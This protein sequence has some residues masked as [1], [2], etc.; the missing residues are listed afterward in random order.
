MSADV[1]HRLIARQRARN[2]VF[3]AVAAAAAVLDAGIVVILVAAATRMVAGVVAAAIAAAV[4]AAVSLGQAAGS[5]RR[6]S[7]EPPDAPASA[8]L[9]PIAA[10]LAAR[11]GIEEPELWIAGDD[12]VNA[13]S[14]ASGGQ[15]TLFYTRGFLAE[16]D[17]SDGPLIEAVT[18]HLLARTAAGDDTATIMSVGLLNWALFLFHR[19]M[20]GFARV[21]RVFGVGYLTSDA[22]QR[23]KP[24]GLG[25]GDDVVTR[26]AVWGISVFIGLCLIAASVGVV[27]VG[28]ILVVVAGGVRLGLTRQRIRIADTIAAELVDDPQALL[29]AFGR[30]SDI[31]QR[32][33]R[34]L[35]L[36]HSGEARRDLCFHRPSHH[37]PGLPVR[38]A[39]AA[40]SSQAAQPGV[41]APIASVLAVACL[42]G[43]VAFATVRVPYGQ[44]FGGAG[45]QVPQANAAPLATVSGQAAGTS[46]PSPSSAS[47]PSPSSSSPSPTSSVSPTSSPSASATSSLPTTPSPSAEVVTP[48]PPPPTSP[49]A[50]TACQPDGTGCTKGGTYP[51]PNA[52]INSD[53]GG[54]EVTWSST[55]VQPYSSGVPL[56]WTAGVTYRNIDSVTLTLGC[57]GSWANASVIQEYMSGGAGDDGM[58][59]AG[60]TTCSQNP[61]W[62]ATVAP[63]H[64]VVVYATFH[65]VPWPGSA[66]AITWGD[67]GTSASIYPFT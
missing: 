43:A 31:G 45:P 58:V 62:T 35:E 8:R 2:R 19:V 1:V 4:M 30:F 60:S 13:F 5:T 38:A 14:A 6:V 41:L 51:D 25:Y 29:A 50:A 39:S 32:G 44:P 23:L 33:D 27:L 22:H 7:G 11:L 37:Y 40:N 57:G 42:I 53:Y 20:R 15:V 49:P 64:T 28:G 48:P 52:V 3:I 59:P 46:A 26:L 36:T 21:L 67:A 63:G 9:R 65:N 55:Y 54:F 10:R 24:S 66:V 56:Y 12:A 18:A 16:F 34:P 61:A 47:L 17:Q